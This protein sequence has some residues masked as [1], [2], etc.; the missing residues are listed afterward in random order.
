MYFIAFNPTN[1]NKNCYFFLLFPSFHF[2]T[3]NT[4][5]IGDS[6][7]FFIASFL[8]FYIFLLY[9]LAVFYFFFWLSYSY[10]IHFFC[11]FLLFLLFIAIITGLLYYYYIFIIFLL[12]TLTIPTIRLIQ[13]PYK[14][15]KPKNCLLIFFLCMFIL[16]A[17]FNSPKFANFNALKC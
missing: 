4:L 15:L 6:Y 11:S 8:H 9:F 1:S 14:I 7:T 5:Q 3:L 10:F 2:Y 16:K 12:F 13:K 17:I